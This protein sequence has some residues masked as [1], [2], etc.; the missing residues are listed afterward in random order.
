MSDLKVDG[1]I[2]STGTNTALTL[3]GKGSGKV[4]IGDGALSFPDADGDADQVIKTDGSGALAFVTPASGGAWTLI[5]TDDASDDATLDVTGLD[6]TYDTYAIVISGLIPATDNSYP[7]FRFGDSS[8]V[9]SGASDYNWFGRSLA[10]ASSPAEVTLGDVSDSEI[11]MIYRAGGGDQV[12]NAVTEGFSAVLFF[13]RANVASFARIVGQGFYSSGNAEK[14][15]LW[16]TGLRLAAIT[17][18]RVQVLFNSGNVTT[19]RLTVWGLA[20]A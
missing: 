5:G 16:I 3:Q 17:V 20:H 7:F 11:Q 15:T 8:G 18:D 14:H 10:E 1:I 9:D 6:G 4:D 19:G 12:G 13:D 2:A